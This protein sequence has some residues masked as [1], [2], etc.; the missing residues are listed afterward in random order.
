MLRQESDPQTFSSRTQ[1]QGW[2]RNCTSSEYS[3]IS[4]R[5][6]GGGWEIFLHVELISCSCIEDLKIWPSSVIS[7]NHI[8]NIQYYSSWKCGR[9]IEAATGTCIFRQISVVCLFSYLTDKRWWPS[10]SINEKS[11]NGKPGW[12]VQRRFHTLFSS[13][14]NDLTILKYFLRRQ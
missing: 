3:G 10:T 7:V 6:E 11:L 13:F 12:G 4:D 2:A 1:V 14:L 8:L 9:H 5:L